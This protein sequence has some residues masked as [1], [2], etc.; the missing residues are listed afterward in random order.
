MPLNNDFSALQSDRSR[1]LSSTEPPIA[2]RGRLRIS[3]WARIGFAGWRLPL[4][5]RLEVQL[6][7]SLY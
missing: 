4:G 7:F 5:E 6:Q 2:P 1:M 3:G